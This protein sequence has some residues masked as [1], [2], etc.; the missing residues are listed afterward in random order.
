MLIERFQVSFVDVLLFYE[1]VFIY[2]DQ[3]LVVAKLLLVDEFFGLVL[4]L[5]ILILFH[6]VI[7]LIELCLVLGNCFSVGLGCQDHVFK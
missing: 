3:F 5:E 6:M 1:H 4:F 7:Y 2:C